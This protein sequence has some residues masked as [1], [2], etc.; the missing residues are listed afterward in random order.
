MHGDGS[1]LFCMQHKFNS[2]GGMRY[3]KCHTIMQYLKAKVKV[4]KRVL[5]KNIDLLASINARVKRMTNE[6]KNTISV[7]RISKREKYKA[8]K[9]KIN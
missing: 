1:K 2:N 4:F 8:L 5:V 3:S 9:P 7:S 6:I